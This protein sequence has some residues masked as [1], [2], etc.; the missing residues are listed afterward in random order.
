MKGKL[1]KVAVIYLCFLIFGV[2]FICFHAK[3]E[4]SEDGRGNELVLLNRIEQ[5]QGGTTKNTEELR[6]YI[7]ATGAQRYEAMALQIA[8]YFIGIGLLYTVTL[9]WYVYRKILRPFEKLESYAE[10]VAAGDLDISLE[11][12]RTNYFGAFTWA[13]DHMKEEIKYAKK[14]EKE[15]IEGNKTVIASLSHDIKT[16]IASIRAYSE[17]LEAGLDA[18][19]KIRQ[20]YA[21]T[22]MRKCDEVTAL[23]NDLVLHSLSELEKLEIQVEEIEIGTLLHQIVEELEFSQL[24][25]VEP[26][27][28]EVVIADKKRVAQIIENLINNA[29]KYAKNQAVYIRTECSDKKY[30]IYVKD[31]GTG[32]PPED[33]PFILQKFYRGKNA[34]DQPGS[35]LGLFIVNYLVEAMGGE[36]E[37]HNS[38]QGLEVIFSLKMK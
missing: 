9:L 23:V 8:P 19:Y 30:F 20:K 4:V 11:Y 32:I 25:L 1:I 21:H 5:E 15:A 34:G 10:Q 18:D 3:Q 2:L 17:G 35:G 13:F 28:N 33:V 27:E 22:I 36:V 37:I 24:H 26:I 14:R 16:P 12:E 7:E 31:T 29:R 6:A 38:E